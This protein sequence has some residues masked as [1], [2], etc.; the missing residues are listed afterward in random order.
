MPLTIDSVQRRLDFL[1]GHDDRRY[2]KEQHGKR[3]PKEPTPKVPPIGPACAR[4]IH[5]RAPSRHDDFGTC[6]QL[7]ITTE[8]ERFGGVE[9]GTVLSAEEASRR[10]VG[11]E[12][13]PSKPWFRC[14]RF[15]DGV[16]TL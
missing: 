2:R 13:L 11:W 7:A 3:R 5:W 12:L 16:T 6:R 15:S 8:R 4:C 14:S 9:K 10:D 1:D